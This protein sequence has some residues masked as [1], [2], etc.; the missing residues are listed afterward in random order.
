MTLLPPTT[1]KW[2]VVSADIFAVHTRHARITTHSAIV[3]VAQS[4]GAILLLRFVR[5]LEKYV[6]PINVRHLYFALSAFHHCRQLAQVINRLN[7]HPA[8]RTTRSIQIQDTHRSL[9][10][11]YNKQMLS[12]NPSLFLAVVAVSVAFWSIYKRSQDGAND[13]S[14]LTPEQNVSKWKKSMR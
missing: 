13:W 2:L 10:T 4:E 1:H 7:V 9:S 3:P 14:D 8:T 12:L 11:R 6:L 5:T